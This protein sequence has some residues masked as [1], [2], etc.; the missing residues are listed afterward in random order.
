[1]NAAYTYIPLIK[2]LIYVKF[3]PQHLNLSST[4][5]INPFWRVPTI[6]MIRKHKVTITYNFCQCNINNIKYIFDTIIID[7]MFFGN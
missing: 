2:T 4:K 3:S 1:M 7:E 6:I 5:S